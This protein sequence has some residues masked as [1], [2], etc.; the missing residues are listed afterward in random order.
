MRAAR[1]ISLEARG[2]KARPASQK[3]RAGRSRQDDPQNPTHFQT[4]RSLLAIAPE[5]VTEVVE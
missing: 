4:M 3:T 1:L 5:K 2:E